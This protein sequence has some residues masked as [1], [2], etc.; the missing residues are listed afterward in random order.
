MVYR[1]V[2][3]EREFVA[4]RYDRIAALVAKHGRSDPAG[5]LGEFE[6]A[7][8]REAAQYLL[9]IPVHEENKFVKLDKVRSGVD[10]CRA[11]PTY[12]AIG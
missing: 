11:L 1:W 4:Q 6:D 9:T 5:L 3:C 10:G 2:D 12:K 7:L 8:R